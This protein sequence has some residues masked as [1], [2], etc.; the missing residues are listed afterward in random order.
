MSQPSPDVTARFT[1]RVDDYVRWRPSYPSDVIRL[2]QETTGI[3]P[4]ATVADIGAGTGISAA[5]LLDAGY[6]V[7]AVEPNA[8]MRAAADKWLQFRPGYHSHPG[9]A[10]ATQLPEASVDLVLAAQAFHWFEPQATGLEWRRILKPPGW[11]VLLW[12]ARRLTGS[13]FL[14]GYERLLLEFATD[15]TAVRHENVDD[16][17]RGSVLGDDVQEFVLTNAQSLDREAVQGRL[18][19]SSYAPTADHPRFAAMM[20]ALDRL[21]DQTAQDG[22][23]VMEYDVT[24]FIGRLSASPMG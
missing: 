19:S 11:V 21:F 22:V 3:V 9:R 16:V 10:E 14:E 20:E 6:E 18:R 23:V 15:Y 17:R 8:A 1:D 2:L 12:N 13:P 24:L 4:P 7:H 5:L